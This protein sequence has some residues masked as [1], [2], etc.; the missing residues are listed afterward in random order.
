MCETRRASS[1]RRVWRTHGDTSRRLPL[2]ITHARSLVLS[3]HHTHASGGVDACSSS[4]RSCRIRGLHSWH[5]VQKVNGNDVVI[6]RLKM[7]AAFT[8]ALPQ[9][10]AALPDGAQMSA[11]LRGG[12]ARAPR[13]LRAPSQCSQARRETA[14]SRGTAPNEPNRRRAV[15]TLGKVALAKAGIALH[16][17]GCARDTI[18]HSDEWQINRD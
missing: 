1:C 5:S 12:N 2:P 4:R 3:R 13:G 14:K 16:R 10:L 18:R 11:A 7:L 9:A 6:T 15:A 17:L 8:A